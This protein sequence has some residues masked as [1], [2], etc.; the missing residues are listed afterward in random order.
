MGTSMP[1]PQAKLFLA[2]MYTDPGVRDAALQLFLERYGVC[3]TV[4]GPILVDSYTRY[5]EK[6]MG[7]SLLKDFLFYRGLITL[8]TLPDVKTFTNQIEERFSLDGRRTVNL[9][10][11]YLTQDKLVLASTKNFLHRIYL[12]KG[13][14]GEV[15]L[16]YRNNRYRYFSWTYPD[17][18]RL[19]V[20]SFLDFQRQRLK[21]G[22]DQR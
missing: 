11:G 8:D 9:D 17:Y 7:S 2:I 12:G 22:Y 1:A 20:Q 4:L 15:T 16:H 10:P 14:F 21:D 13:I 19:D 3:D 6:E 18:R 5:Y